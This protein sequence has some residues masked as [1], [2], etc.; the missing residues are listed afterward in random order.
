MDRLLLQTFADPEALCQAAAR[1]FTLRAIEAVTARNRFF[2]ALSG[3]STPRRL[4]RLLSEPPFRDQVEWSRV[5]LFW[6]DERCVPPDH[7]DS[8]YRMANEALVER[9]PI[10]P[11]N[12]HRLP[13]E[14]SDRDAAAE[15]YAHTMAATFDAAGSPPVFD[16][17]LLGMGPDAHTAS[18]FPHTAALAETGRWVAAN[19]VP[20]LNAHRLTLTYPVLNRA[21][22]VLFLVAGAD[23]AGPLFE[24]FAGPPDPER[25]PSQAVAPV[26]GQLVWYADAAAV[27]R[28]TAGLGRKDEG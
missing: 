25:L 3:G 2:V 6:G 23:K 26:Q 24:V 18:L 14:Q 8:N 9:V 10:P 11:A 21:R 16:L 28:L 12:V 4:Y 22:E 20:K 13:A 17:V 15:E 1:E 19:F 27:A 5:E 7:A